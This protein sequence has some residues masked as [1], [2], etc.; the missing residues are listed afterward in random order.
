M[1]IQKKEKDSNSYENIYLKR[2]HDELDSQ[3]LV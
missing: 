1:R 3:I 2:I